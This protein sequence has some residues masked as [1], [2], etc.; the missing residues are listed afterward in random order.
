MIYGVGI[1]ILSHRNGQEAKRQQNWTFTGET[2]NI[3]ILVACRNEENNIRNLLRDLVNQNF[4]KDKLKITLINDHSEDGT[5]AVCQAFMADHPE[6]T[7][8]LLRLPEGVQG[9]KA[10]LALG[11]DKSEGAFL[12]FTDADCRLPEH[13][14][15]DMVI[16]Q[17]NSGADMVCG[18]VEMKVEKWIQHAEA[19]EFSSLIAVGAASFAINKPSLC[20][21]A[22]YMITAQALKEANTSRKDNDLASG[23]DVF[24]LHK[25]I[26]LGRKTSFCRVPLASVQIGTHHSWQ[27]FMAQRIRWAGKWNSGIP[28]GNKI[29]AVSVWLFHL[30]FLIGLPVLFRFGGPN[31]LL[32]ALAWKAICETLLL[33]PFLIKKGYRENSGRV[34]LAQIP[35]SMYVVVM[36]I[37]ILLSKRYVWKGRES[38]E[39]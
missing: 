20:N 4:P 12:L 26:E 23:D 5:E 29:L 35:Y 15:S 16:C 28:G 10:A 8:N 2:P 9:K 7:F 25:L 11:I 24:L 1:L 37:R 22:N 6:I 21:A 13:W 34:W 36:G 18:S 33:E 39:R 27:G 3:S 17:Q 38:D 19:L 31:P 30:I 14:I 32:I